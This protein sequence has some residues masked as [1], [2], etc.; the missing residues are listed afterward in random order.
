[1]GFGAKIRQVRLEKGLIQ[2]QVSKVLGYPTDSYISDVENNKFI[3]QPDKLE[4]IA[5]ILDLTMEDMENFILEDKL[6]KLGMT[7]PAFTMMF[8]EVPK[9]TNEEKHSLIRAYEAVLKARQTK[10]KT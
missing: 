3:P 9:M 4:K 8:K 5:E 2:S 10:R 7:D 6:E 1:M